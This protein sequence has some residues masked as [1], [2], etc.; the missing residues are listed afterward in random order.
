M[1]GEVPFPIGAGALVTAGTG[2]GKSHFIGRLQ[3]FVA[4]AAKLTAYT[5][6]LDCASIVSMNTESKVNTLECLFKRARARSPSVLFLDN[7]G[8]FVEN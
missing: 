8:S 6:V 7:L 4:C 2:H 1:N 5:E 3:E